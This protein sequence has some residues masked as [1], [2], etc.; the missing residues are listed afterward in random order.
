M[1]EDTGKQDDAAAAE[2]AA[3]L[4]ADE[5]K[6]SDPNAAAKAKNWSQYSSLTP[7]V[8]NACNQCHSKVQ[9]AYIVYQLPAAPPA[10]LKM[11][12]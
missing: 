5:K 10:P 2:W 6:A 4:D 11:S 12:K 8:V 7:Q 9:M 3:M 1:A